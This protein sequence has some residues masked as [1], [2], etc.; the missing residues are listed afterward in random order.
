M[1]QSVQRLRRD[2]KL[3]I[4][5]GVILTVIVFY[6]INYYFIGQGMIYW[7]LVET[8]V[9]WLVIISL[10][11]LADNQRILNEELKDILRESIK[12]SKTLKQISREQLEEIKL[13][14]GSKKK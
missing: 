1:F 7:A 10:L 11:I 2:E 4:F 13:L 5:L 12:E 9:M 6:F 8:G 14:R 3:I